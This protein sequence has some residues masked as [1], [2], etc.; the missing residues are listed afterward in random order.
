[1]RGRGGRCSSY[2][3]A[4]GRSSRSVAAQ[5]KSFGFYRG[6]RQDFFQISRSTRGWIAWMRPESPIIKCEPHL[7]VA[8]I[9]ENRK[10]CRRDSET[11]RTAIDQ[12]FD[13][14]RKSSRLNSSHVK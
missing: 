3:R 12:S 14:D 13:R 2:D 6:R 4:R 8:E 9:A 10:A 7:E 11:Q 1:M 5:W